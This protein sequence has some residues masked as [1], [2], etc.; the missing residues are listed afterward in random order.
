V[1]ASYAK[2]IETLQRHGFDKTE[3]REDIELPVDV[4]RVQ[5]IEKA[6]RK[7]QG[8][9]MNRIEATS[10]AESRRVPAGTVIVSTKGPLGSLAALLLEP[11]SEDGLATWNFFD[12]GL[13]DGSE[14]PVLRLT[15]DVPVV[16]GALRPLGDER[17]MNRPIDLALVY[18]QGQTPNFSGNPVSGLTW[19]DDGERF[20]QQKRGTMYA[21]HARTGKLEPFYETAKMEN[22]LRALPGLEEATAQ[23]LS[24][25]G[26]FAMNPSRTAARIEF[27][28]DYLLAFFDGKPA[29]RLTKSAPGKELPTFS[30]DGK[31]LAFVRAGNLF[32][33]DVATQSEKAL[34]TDGGGPILNGRADWVYEEEIFNRV[35]HP[36]WWSP[37]STR[38]AFMRFDDT[39]VK[40]FTVVNHIPTRLNVEQVSYPKAGDPNPLVKLGIAAID[41]TT[42]TFVDF[43]G[44]DPKDFLIARVGWT[45]D[46]KSVYCYVQNRVQSWLDVCLTSLECTSPV[47]KLFRDTTRAW[48]DDTGP[49]HF[50]ADGTFLY[51]SDRS[52]WRHIYRFAAEGKLLNPVS[53]GDWE[54]KSIHRIDDEGGWI[55]FAATK[56]CPHGASELRAKF[57]GSTV[58]R[59]T[60][61]PGTHT[62][63]VSPKGNLLVDSYSS[64]AGPTKVVLR[65]ADGSIVRTLDSNPVYSREE[66][67]F[68]K[69]EPVEI[70]GWAMRETMC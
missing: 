7:F 1:P 9:V 51:C 60:P 18:G 4:Y 65:S 2:A 5:R 25:R 64:L 44:Y 59:L 6:P 34:T 15:A 66:Y 41:G 16:A 36:F 50:L 61:E 30:P 21:V 13:A 57:D 38:I 14:F 63:N 35:A 42:P 68:G 56:D 37:D 52:G 24:R 33:V 29:I 69:V 45:P 12:A 23:T 54:I 27:Q 31:H 26:T 39:P 49:I 62:S 22:S 70:H 32:V 17:T 55:Y 47:R 20:L 8:H 58:E 40:A 67:Q 28:G 43:T 10:A 53:H 3:L 19:L 11:Q 46:S 48:V